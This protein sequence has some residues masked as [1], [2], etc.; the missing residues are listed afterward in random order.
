[1]SVEYPSNP[2]IGDQ[3]I[4]DGITR[5][6]DGTTW[7]IVPT[8]IVGPTGP[9]GPTGPIG[10][11]GPTGPKGDGYYLEY[12]VGV[13]SSIWTIN[14]D[15][16]AYPNVTIINSAGDQVEGDVDY[17]SN[18]IITITFSAPFAGTAILT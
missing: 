14:H 13:A 6:W 11:T 12:P 10:P 8:L 17:V 3:F 1:V 16:N 18:Y 4:V 9:T 7:D 2:S 5:E 15:F